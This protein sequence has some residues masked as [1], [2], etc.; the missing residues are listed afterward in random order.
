[1]Q[2]I[3]TNKDT[4]AVLLIDAKN[5]LNSNNR[6]VILHN[7]NFIC[8]VITTYITNCYITPA[9]LF[10]IDGGEILSKEGTNQ[11]DATAMGA[12]E[13]G[14]LPLMN[15]LLEFISINHLTAKEVSFADD[16]FTVAGKLT[17][18]RHYWKKLTSLGLKYGHFPKA[19]KSYLIVK[20]EKL[21]EARNVSNNSN[22][23]ITIEG[24]RHLHA[25]IG[26]NIYRE[27][28]L[29]DLIID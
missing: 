2:D 3:F 5:A 28:Y 11:G 26:S 7:L 15:F 19:S 9:R 4:E 14:I 22:V 24:K 1:M 6:M 25:V 17:S 20:E 12:Y 8:P 18:I 29:K 21:S 27:K 13:L 23:N 16:G 10:I